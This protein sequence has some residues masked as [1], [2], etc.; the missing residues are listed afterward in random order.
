MDRER[1]MKVAVVGYS[2]SGKSTL[3]VGL[4][5][6]LGCPVLHLD[7]VQF[8]PGWRIRDR[9]E[10]CA[11]VEG[12]LDGERDGWVIDGNY[13]KLHFER[14][15]AE[16]DLILFMKFPRCV[17]LF[18][19]LYRNWKYRGKVRE[20]IAEGCRE[21]MDWEF[22][23]WIIKNGRCGGHKEMF[24]GLT[25]CYPDKVMI[26]KNHRQTRGYIE[27]LRARLASGAASQG[28]EQWKDGENR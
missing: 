8:L 10:A 2:G 21:K 4:G 12:F 28:M 13:G 7:K 9:D 19:A 17:C 15:M 11:M 14:R 20:S 1:K 16:A 26:V 22:F 27:L 25:A 23:W 24:D 3:A 18:Q 5:A 6:L